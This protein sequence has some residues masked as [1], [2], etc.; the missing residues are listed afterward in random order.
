[1]QPG[2]HMKHLLIILLACITYL[3]WAD[4]GVDITNPKQ[5]SVLHNLQESLASVTTAIMGCIDSGNSHGSCICK[6]KVLITQ[7]NKNTNKLFLDHPEFKDLD[8]VRF[9]SPEGE[10]IALSL[11]G[12]RKQ[13]SVE[14][15]CT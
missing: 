2:I 11:E 13:A 4:E 15:S 9:K 3:A 10:H 14:P 8:L 7:L 1:M 12:I 6:H 5:V